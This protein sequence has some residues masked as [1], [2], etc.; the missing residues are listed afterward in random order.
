MLRK[1]PEVSDP[2]AL[3]EAIE[4]S[5]KVTELLRQPA[6]STLMTA[7]SQ[8]ERDA[9]RDLAEWERDQ[10]RTRRRRLLKLED[11]AER[12]EQRTAAQLAKAAH[13]DRQW[14]Q[15]ALS[16]RRRA[17]TPDAQLARVFRRSTVTARVLIGVV[18][19]GMTWAAI[20]VQSNLVPN[21][22]TSNPLWWISFGIEAMFSVPLILIMVHS[23]TAA[24]LGEETERGTIVLLEV[25][26]LGGSIALNAGPHYFTG[27][28]GKGL[29]F[30]AAPVMIGVAIWLHAWLSNRYARLISKTLEAAANAPEAG[31]SATLERLA[32]TA[33]A[34]DRCEPALAGASLTSHHNTLAPT[35]ALAPRTP[36]LAVPEVPLAPATPAQPAP[37]GASPNASP[38]AAAPAPVEPEPERNDQAADAPARTAADQ[39]NH[40]TAAPT[41]PAGA[42][43][44]AGP[45]EDHSAAPAPAAAAPTPTEEALAPSAAGTSLAL[46]TGASAA[47]HHVDLAP[48][49]AAQE[50]ALADARSRRPAP[51][52]PSATPSASNASGAA[53]ASAVVRALPASRA[54]ENGPDQYEV[55]AGRIRAAGLVTKPTVEQI[56]TVLRM[57]DEGESHAAITRATAPN[58]YTGGVHH[59]TIKAIAAAAE[60]VKVPVRA[61]R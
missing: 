10:K 34:A 38:A 18:L 5:A 56:T 40:E 57:L 49:Q 44:D 50:P 3:R 15:R 53:G 47:S 11:R 16:A 13:Q 19:L 54:D 7:P 52:A 42:S 37:T 32:P 59:K 36:H 60:Q 26:L 43:P 45:F 46:S 12:R 29:E 61:V 27:D 9:D 48:A 1:K 4:R 24:E 22:D 8:R 33:A 20:N 31:A 35:A 25:A 51:P 41:A 2:T 21:H 17:L 39:D 23:Q 28:L 30:S 58:S 6:A 55:L 14:L